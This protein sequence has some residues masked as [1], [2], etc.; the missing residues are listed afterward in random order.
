MAFAAFAQVDLPEARVFDGV[1]FPLTLGPKNKDS[2]TAAALNTA[3]EEHREELIELAMKHGAVLF[4]GFDTPKPTDFADAI[5]S[6]KLE[7]MP[8]V[9]GA[10]VRTNVVGD[11]VFTA[12]ESPP[13]EPIPFHHEMAQV[14]DPPKYVMFFCEYPAK[15]GGETPIV[16][17]H[18]VYEHFAA[19]FPEVCEKCETLGV[20]YIRV[21]PLEDDATSA[22]GRSWR[23]TFQVSTKREAEAT[24][25]R[26][27][28]EWEWLPGDELRTITKIIP[29]VRC[30]IRTKRK[31][32]YNSMV[33]AFTGWVDSRND[34]TKAVVFGDGS[35]MD[36]EAM[37][38]MA[39]AMNNLKV[40][41]AWQAKD[42][43]VVDNSVAMHARHTFTPPRRIL[44]AVT[45]GPRLA[46]DAPPTIRLG[47]GDRMPT[48]GF[49][50][51]KVPRNVTAQTV[52]DAI[53]IG[54][55]HL[56]CACDYGNEAEVG[57]GIAQAIE[58]G[59]VTRE[60]LWITSKLWNTYHHPSHVTLACQKS[61]LDLQLDYVDLYLIHFPISLKFVPFE[62]R[63]PPEWVFDPTSE[64]PCMEFSKVPLID[65][66]RAME[67]L[68]ANGFAKNIGL[69]NF[70]TQALRDLLSYAKIPPAVLQVELHPYNSQPKLLRFCAENGIA[71]TAFSPLGHASYVQLNMATE[72]ES[73]MN[74]SVVQFIAKEHNKTPAQIVL[75]WGVQRGTSIIPKTAVPSR[76][77][78]N[79][80]VFDFELSSEQ[81]A[82]IDALNKNRRFND[83]GV[84]CEGMNT[85]CPIY[86]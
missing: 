57:Q 14:P 15:E 54:Y 38:G 4:R 3:I 45:R 1:V 84:F 82:V 76:M 75:R 39:Q 13:S 49:G 70:N 2:A 23:N 31:T 9:G 55:R 6:F 69:A 46:S 43:I 35:P 44:A 11:V 36:A 27:G 33:A 61:L 20:R 28:T 26:I 79:A 77:I 21:M 48:V 52:C 18:K 51:W 65:T 59:L 64:H 66:W 67:S 41:F 16:L 24:M 30:D 68:V 37:H 12:N 32:F 50:L 29:A 17:S 19:H 86:E 85:F 10:A 81:M 42:I 8:Y 22:I 58:Q 47:T 73:A 60:E 40:A 5:E 80:A 53:A 34:P 56:D 72:Q 74:E 83:P 71:V 62:H 78:E 63:Y 7:N 25:R